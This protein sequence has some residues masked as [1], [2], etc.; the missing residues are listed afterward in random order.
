VTGPRALEGILK[1]VKGEEGLDS[2][3]WLVMLWNRPELS[4]YIGRLVMGEKPS[5]VGHGED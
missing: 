1:A 4:L 2:G 5:E 3:L